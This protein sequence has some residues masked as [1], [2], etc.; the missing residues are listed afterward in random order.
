MAYEEIVAY[1]AVNVANDC[2]DPFFCLSS[3]F[4]EK[5]PQLCLWPILP[6]I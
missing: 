1:R 4:L 3:S 6:L 2:K 5:W